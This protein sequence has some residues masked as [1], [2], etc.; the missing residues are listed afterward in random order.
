VGDRELRARKKIEYNVHKLSEQSVFVPKPPK[1]APASKKKKGTKKK[2]KGAGTTYL[3]L[4]KRALKNVDPPGWGVA[5]ILRFLEVYV[6]LSHFYLFS[7]I[8]YL[9]VF[10]HPSHK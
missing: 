2:T 4:V 5:K 8:L 1:K 9:L 6:S 10:S 3:V 7:L